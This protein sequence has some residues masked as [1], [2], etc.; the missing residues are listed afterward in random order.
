MRVDSI[1]AQELRVR[2]NRDEGGWFVETWRQDP[3]DGSRG[4]GSAIYFLLRAGEA[5]HWHRIDA[6]EIWHFY[7]GEPLQLRIAPHGQPPQTTVL[8]PDPTA[9]QRPQ[10]IVPAQAWQSAEPLGAYTLVG[11]TVSP[12]FEF[13]GFE[14]APQGWEP[15]ASG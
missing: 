9:G 1:S 14:L 5:S 13:D 8:G 15:P 11:A 2:L 4:S 7:A 10:V 3:V 12:A 6:T